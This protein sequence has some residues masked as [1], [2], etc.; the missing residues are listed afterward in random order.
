MEKGARILFMGTPEFAIPSLRILLENNCNIV[1]VVTAPD[2]PAGRGKKITT[3]PIKNFAVENN[4]KVLQPENLKDP[5]FN[6]ELA[7]LHPDIQVVVA[8][9]M[10]PRM[11]WQLPSMGTFNLHASLLPNYRGAAPINWAIINGESETGITTFFIN[12]QIDTGDI[13]LQESVSIA[14]QQTA[15]ELHD[16]LMEKGSQLVLKTVLGISEGS[17]KPS[18][19]PKLKDIQSAPKIFKEDCKINWS[20]DV[21]TIFNKIRGLSP[22]P[23]AWFTV[24]KSNNDKPFQI[25]IFSANIEVLDH[26]NPPGTLLTDNKTYWKACCPNGY[27]AFKEVQAEGKKRNVITDF[28]RGAM[29][30]NQ[31]IVK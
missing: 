23:G 30:V 10:L 7:D 24:T 1:G 2:K 14:N 19:Q 22:F 15:G 21:H 25:K 26:K 18:S 6:Q 4:L 8:F 11:V 9:R 29:E 27:I 16:E 3:S 31:W 5:L 17:L 12:E 20:N 13:L 28:L